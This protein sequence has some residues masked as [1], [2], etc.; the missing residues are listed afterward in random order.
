MRGQPHSPTEGLKCTVKNKGVI[1]NYFKFVNHEKLQ[2][3]EIK[4]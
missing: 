1:F 3:P 4:M 2:S